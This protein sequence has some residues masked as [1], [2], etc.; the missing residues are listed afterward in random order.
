MCIRVTTLS[1]YTKARTNY[2]KKK[3]NH[4]PYYY[5]N[6]TNI[7]AITIVGW[8]LRF[9]PLSLYISVAYGF[10]ES[11]L[12]NSTSATDWQMA[13]RSDNLI[14]LHFKFIYVDFLNQIRY[15]SIVSYPIFSRGWV[16]PFPDLN[17]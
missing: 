16:N 1:F 6:S 3:Q 5:I 7:A 12:V 2:I 14:A 4:H 15:F 9:S 17:E 11:N 10:Q 8:V 13:V